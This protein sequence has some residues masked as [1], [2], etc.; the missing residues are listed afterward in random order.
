VGTLWARQPP[1]VLAGRS[2]HSLGAVANAVGVRM[3]P[4]CCPW[5]I[6]S[7]HGASAH[8]S[9]SGPPAGKAVP[10]G[11]RRGRGLVYSPHVGP[12]GCSS[13]GVLGGPWGCPAVG[14]GWRVHVVAPR[15]PWGAKQDRLWRVSRG[16]LRPWIPAGAVQR[17]GAALGSPRRHKGR[18]ALAQGYPIRC[19]RPHRHPRPPRRVR[20]QRCRPAPCSHPREPVQQERGPTGACAPIRVGMQTPSRLRHPSHPKQQV[21]PAQIPPPQPPAPLR[22][23]P[24]PIC[25]VVADP[26]CP[27][28]PRFHSPPTSVCLL[29]LCLHWAHWEPPGTPHIVTHPARS[30]G[31]GW[32]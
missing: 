21:P 23:P 6:V 22:G 25:A 3:G 5:G 30:L 29:P 1:A 14:C 31:A 24:A 10:V 28:A 15:G 20:G 19:P 2:W 18:R 27:A 32:W 17:A 4:A 7:S 11:Q 12:H 9:C 26:R 8:D 16:P 13:G